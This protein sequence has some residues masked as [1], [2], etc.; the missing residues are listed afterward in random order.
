M[1]E[2]DV[3]A[4]EVLNEVTATGIDPY[5]NEVSDDDDVTVKTGEPKKDVPPSPVPTNPIPRTGDTAPIIGLLIAAI[6]AGVV[7]VGAARKR[8]MKR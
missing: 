2:D 8:S 7:L 4:G 1:T 3:D 6:V 5:G